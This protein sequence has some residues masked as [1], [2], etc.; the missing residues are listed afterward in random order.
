MGINSP[1]QTADPGLICYF[2]FSALMQLSCLFFSFDDL[3][4]P[5]SKIPV[6]WPLGPKIWPRQTDKLFV[7]QMSVNE[8]AEHII[9]QREKKYTHPQVP[10]L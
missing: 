8:Q 7:V 6:E 4:R 1:H 10:Q 9:L 5:L 3:D 2:C